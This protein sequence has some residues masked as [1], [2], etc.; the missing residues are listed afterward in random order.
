[1][2]GI[3]VG[4][5]ARGIVLVSIAGA[6]I[7]LLIVS[8]MRTDIISDG[9]FLSDGLFVLA[10]TRLFLGSTQGRLWIWCK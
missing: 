9:L 3:V 4:I 8:V 6:G 5:I 10:P 7:V 2:R 1:M